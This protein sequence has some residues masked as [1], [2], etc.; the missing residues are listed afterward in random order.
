[1]VRLSFSAGKKELETRT[2]SKPDSLSQQR[3]HFSN[4]YDTLSFYA[5]SSLWYIFLMEKRELSSLTK[6]LQP[7]TEVSI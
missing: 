5:S 3:S 1:V 2:V 6:Q 7:Y 4:H